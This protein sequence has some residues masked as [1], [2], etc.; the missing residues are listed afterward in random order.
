MRRWS[1]WIV[2]FAATGALTAAWSTRPFAAPPT[3]SGPEVVT[4]FGPAARVARDALSGAPRA[5]SG[6]SIATV[7]DSP[8]AR[9]LG[10]VATHR[11]ALG[12]GALEVAADRSE[13]L[14]SGGQA[15]TL[16]ATWLGAEVEGRSLVVRLDAEGRV[17]GVT[18][19]LFALTTPWPAEA[20][21]AERAR[22]VVLATFD[23]AAAGR[24]TEVVVATA[25]GSVRF[26]WRVAAVV[27]PLQAH[28]WVWVDQET[29]AVLRSAPAGLDQG[30]TRLP[31]KGEGPR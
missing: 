12:L 6:L 25:P 30:M 7:G 5:I 20:I 22:E 23:V 16:R 11:A 21:D 27:I 17:R 9:A 10:F 28:F 15:V 2:S 24:P 26:A 19:D 14:P 4:T 8:A 31:L 29:G 18:N 13:T 3:G 1:S